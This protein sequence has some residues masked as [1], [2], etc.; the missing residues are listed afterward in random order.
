MSEPTE[1]DI[2]AV[3]TCLDGDG[4]PD[5]QVKAAIAIRWMCNDWRKRNAPDKGPEGYP[6]SPHARCLCGC[7]RQDHRASD[8]AC[9]I[10]PSDGPVLHFYEGNVWRP[11]K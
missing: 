3:E 11:S 2:K 1:A 6:Y 5:E 10:L 7:E 9:P 4:S 8:E